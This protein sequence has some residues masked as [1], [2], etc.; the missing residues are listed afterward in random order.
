MTPI[1]LRAERKGDMP[2]DNC[3]GEDQN[4][5]DDRPKA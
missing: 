2:K 3:C 5:G 4:D 1:D